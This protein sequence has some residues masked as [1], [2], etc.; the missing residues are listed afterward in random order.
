MKRF[1]L[2]LTAA[3][4][5]APKGPAPAISSYAGSGCVELAVTRPAPFETARALVPARYKLSPGADGQAQIVV[6]I[7]RCDSFSIDGTSAPGGIVTEHAIRIEAPDGSP[8]RHGYLLHHATTV[9]A[10]ASALAPLSG[11]FEFAEEGSY[12]VGPRT[13]G[14][15]NAARASIRSARFS[16]SLTGDPVTE[17]A[18]APV[19]RDA[20]GFDLWLDHGSERIKLDYRLP[21]IYPRSTG[22]IAARYQGGADST[23][24]GAFLRFDAKVLI[25]R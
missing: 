25:T 2:V 15:A 13:P 14:A 10:L 20:K 4:A 22:T 24:G 6:A 7:Y 8:G 5:S 17:P 18:D 12:D 3:C 11:I 21:Q 9:R 23:G 19:E 16:A 1:L